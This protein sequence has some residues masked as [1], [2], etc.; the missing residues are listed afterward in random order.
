MSAK[1][2]FLFSLCLVFFACST[3]PRVPDEPPAP[4]GAVQSLRLTFAGDIMAH[5]VNFSMA[6]Y[7]LIYKD[8]ESI[9]QNDDLSFANFETPVYADIPYESY[10]TFNVQPPYARAAI[11]AGFDV[12]SLANN[13]TNDQGA[14]GIDATAAFFKSQGVYAAGIKPSP[15]SPL[16]FEIIEINGWKI[17]F[18]AITEIL[19]SPV[20]ANRIDYIQPAKQRR[21]EFTALIA[22]LKAQNPCDIF[23]LSIHSGEEEYIHSVAESQKKYYYSLLDAGVDI[24]WAN[25]VHIA[26]GWEMFADE[27]KDGIGKIIFYSAGNTISGQRM[28][29]NLADP[30]NNRDYTG[31]GLLFSVVIE[32]IAGSEKN[33]KIA[34]VEPVVITTY[35][36]SEN[37][38][39]IKRLSDSFINSLRENDKNDEAAYF[40]KRKELMESIKG[41]RNE[42]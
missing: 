8:I 40:E 37:R 14:K 31:D 39:I 16:T 13:H 10:P 24:I 29:L 36:D 20:A 3:T 26:R 1:K 23:V 25:H 15:D 4:H 7:S 9:L 41:K 33:W 38:F 18:A 28:R 12:F 27:K 2:F 19:N 42:N 5:A 35:R 11:D 30:A 32:R 34:S 22:A 6:D 17:L 21:E